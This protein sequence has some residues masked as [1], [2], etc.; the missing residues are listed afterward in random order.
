[1]TEPFSIHPRLQADCHWL[2]PLA[3]SELLLHKDAALPWFIL[4]PRVEA[5]ALHELDR[6]TRHQLDD[7]ADAVAG[8]LVAW[9]GCHRINQASIGNRVPQLHLHVIGRYPGDP[10]WPGVVWGCLD[11]G[12]S[13]G[14]ARLQTI[15][16][17]LRHRLG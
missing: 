12:E 13:Y 15:A 11:S 5:G 14:H 10:C 16:T 7:E 8:F 4:V 3:C 6:P 2:L 9:F 1:M 17:A